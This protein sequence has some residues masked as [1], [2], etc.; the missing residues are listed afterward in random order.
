MKINN[1]IA[2]IILSSIFLV[3]SCNNNSKIETNEQSSESKQNSEN[4]N[5]HVNNLGDNE[6]PYELSYIM[7][8]NNKYPYEVNFLEDSLISL[9][10]KK[11]LNKKYDFLKKIFEV[12]T[13]IRVENFWF[14]SWGMQTH[15]GGDPSAII[16][17]DIK[18]NLIYVELKENDE[19]KFYSENKQD[20]PIDLYKWAHDE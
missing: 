11:L 5:S 10:L 2:V 19:V 6:L 15:S 12:Q 14:Y 18:E 7:K 8:F 17:I 16:V 9:R 20:M 4:N 1:L 13:P 3:S